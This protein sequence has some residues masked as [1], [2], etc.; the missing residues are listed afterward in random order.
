MSGN[1][2]A[3]QKK[4]RLL[5]SFLEAVYGRI[6]RGIAWI[7]IPP[8][9]IVVLEVRGRR[10]GRP[11]STVLVLADY[12]GER[13]LV[14]VIGE[15]SDWVRNVRVA[16][17][18]AVIRHGK[19]RR[20]RLEEVPSPDRAPILKAY[21]KWALGARSVWGLGQGAPLSDFEKLAPDHPVF[22]LRARVP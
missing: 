22:K 18:D 15:Q 12:A 7:G 11:R 21:L 6:F 14:S 5:L 17:G 10:S 4:P 13:Y 9:F 2:S 3:E 19:R 16:D 1:Q 20:M 8:S